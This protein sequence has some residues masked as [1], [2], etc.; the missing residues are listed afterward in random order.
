VGQAAAARAALL[1]SWGHQGLLRDRVLLLLPLHEP[2]E[3]SLAEELLQV[4]GCRA[5]YLTAEPLEAGAVRRVVAAL[6]EIIVAGSQGPTAPD[7]LLGL[8]ADRAA[9][10]PELGRRMREEVRRVR[11]GGLAF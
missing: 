3:P 11:R 4:H 2:L 7:I 9:E 10:A 6:G 5:V 1:R 8:A